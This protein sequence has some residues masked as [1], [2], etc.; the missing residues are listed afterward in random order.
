M[1]SGVD[2]QPPSDMV[3]LGKIVAPYGLRGA[4]K[5]HPF[6]DDPPAWAKLP[7]WWVGK[8][9]DAPALWQPQKLRKCKFREGLLIAELA[10]LNDRNASEAATGLLVGVPHE[11]LPPT[12]ENEYYWADLIGLDVV[13]TRDQ[14]LGKVLGLIETPGND[15]LRVGDG[16]ASERLLPFVAAV[17]LDVDL[18]ARRVRVDWESDW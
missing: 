14:V 11:A 12:A 17:V 3:V 5:V 16:E 18:S 9:G 4:V 7:Q 15:V 1:A 8:E 13:N 2:V 10:D 6:A